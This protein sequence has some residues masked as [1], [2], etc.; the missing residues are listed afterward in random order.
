MYEINLQHATL[1]VQ[2]NNSGFVM[3]NLDTSLMVLN[4]EKCAE[5]TSIVSSNIFD[6]NVAINESQQNIIESYDARN[7][8]AVEL[9]LLKNDENMY[10][11]VMATQDPKTVEI[12]ML[13]NN[14]ASYSVVMET[15]NEI[16]NPN[17][18]ELQLLKNRY[19]VVMTTNVT[20]DPKTVQ[21]QM[22]KNSIMETNNIQG[23]RK[24]ELQLLDHVEHEENNIDDFS[25]IEAKLQDMH[26]EVVTDYCRLCSENIKDAS[27]VLL[28]AEMAEIINGIFP[29]KVAENDTLPQQICEPCN[30]N[31][32]KHYHFFKTVLKAD[33][34]LRSKFK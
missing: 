27:N 34:T 16:K 5:Y 2:E 8:K 13:K 21:L 10:S 12:Q 7:S 14:D 9:Q 15:N 17:A 19:N 29:I 6:P 22:L 33:E 30:E 28:S 4:D 1:T 31:F 20:Q 26:A 23:P 3:E 18:V 25:L 32:K 24:I 11:V